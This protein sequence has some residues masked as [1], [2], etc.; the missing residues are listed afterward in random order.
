MGEILPLSNAPA[1]P[2]PTTSK[3]TKQLRFVERS[4]AKILQQLWEVKTFHFETCACIGC[5]GEWRDVP[6]EIE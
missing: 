1:V 5:H 2:N 6:S 4:G 3:P